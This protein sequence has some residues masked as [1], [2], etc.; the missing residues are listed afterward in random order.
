MIKDLQNGNYFDDLNSYS[1]VKNYLAKAFETIDSTAT[2]PP[3]TTVDKATKMKEEEQ[4]LT[5]LSELHKKCIQIMQQ[6]QNKKAIR[7][8]GSDLQGLKTVIENFEKRLTAKKDLLDE[9]K[10]IEKLIISQMQIV[11][12]LQL[13]F[14]GRMQV[15]YPASLISRVLA[16]IKVSLEVEASSRKKTVVGQLENFI[17]RKPEPDLSAFQLDTE[18]L[19]RESCDLGA[20]LKRTV[21]EEDSNFESLFRDFTR[22]NQKLK[23]E[24]VVKFASLDE[25][26]KCYKSYDANLETV[27]VK[28]IALMLPRQIV[29]EAIQ[30]FL[31]Y[32]ASFCI[33]G[34]KEQ[35]LLEMNN[36][37]QETT[38][39]A[40]IEELNCAKVAMQ[41]SD[42]TKDDL[43]ATVESLPEIA[44]SQTSSR[45]PQ[46]RLS[47]FSL[48][49]P[50]KIAMKRN[51]LRRISE[52]E[53]DWEGLLAPFVQEQDF[54]SNFPLEESSRCMLEYHLTPARAYNYTVN[55][56]SLKDLMQ[57]YALT[58]FGI[59]LSVNDVVREGKRILF[60][61]SENNAQTL[62][63]VH[64]GISQKN[65]RFAALSKVE[66]IKYEERV[67]IKSESNSVH[68]NDQ[69]LK[70]KLLPNAVL[71]K[72]GLRTVEAPDEVSYQIVQTLQMKNQPHFF[73]LD[74]DSNFEKVKRICPTWEKTFDQVKF[75]CLQTD[76]QVS[77]CEASSEGLHVMTKRNGGILKNEVGDQVLSLP[78]VRQGLAL[79]LYQNAETLIAN[80]PSETP[81]ANQV[82][83]KFQE[84]REKERQIKKS[85]VNI[86]EWLHKM[87]KQE[88]K[89]TIQDQV[90]CQEV[91][92]TLDT[93]DED[94]STGEELY[95]QQILSLIDLEILDD[96]PEM[97]VCETDSTK[98]KAYFEEQGLSETVVT[99]EFFKNELRISPS[100]R[101]WECLCARL[102]EIEQN[103]QKNLDKCWS[104]VSKLICSEKIISKMEIKS[105]EIEHITEKKM[106]K[107]SS[108]K[109][110]ANFVKIYRFLCSVECDV[111]RKPID[112]VLQILDAIGEY[113]NGLE[114]PKQLISASESFVNSKAESFE[115]EARMSLKT[116]LRRIQD[117]LRDLKRER[118][119]QASVN[120]KFFADLELD[121]NLDP[122][123]KRFS[124]IVR[125]LADCDAPA[126]E[127]MRNILLNVSHS[128]KLQGFESLLM[129]SYCCF[130][131]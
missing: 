42:E 58:D 90:D 11:S 101:I 13:V 56:V 29:L 70:K 28:D 46:R 19:I 57:Q 36:N 23:S 3:L 10:T 116:R 97:F 120:A 43:D 79:I 82:K 64:N 20:A 88:P 99:S 85:T 22:V 86:E 16:A 128:Q 98:W 54:S 39:S 37:N 80:L 122:K 102:G 4:N 68:I 6:R 74:S 53:I 14:L 78:P 17:I 38:A 126:D 91:S 94:E 73:M 50:L 12:R 40:L 114:A 25:L 107:T 1:W 18:H 45:K 30:Y 106:E 110:L 44:E 66:L 52:L 121:K 108:I 113:L 77:S 83:L 60:R 129:N 67:H 87:L 95:L 49:N 8:S 115:C 130:G 63:L 55:G 125:Q 34:E 65:I 119:K 72:Q 105:A 71:C 100:A 84:I 26:I 109:N 59:E 47:V 27:L 24:N 118:E 35:P 62:L 61:I 111:A 124:A 92:Q 104:I 123:L 81:R 127:K 48:K 9:E 96:K 31:I 7:R 15:I 117:Q 112:E 75:F 5:M 131:F 69:V 33:P 32:N 76:T 2:P 89:E 41:E 51:E 21:D 103:S 93:K